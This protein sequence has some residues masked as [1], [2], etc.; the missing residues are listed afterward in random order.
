MADNRQPRAVRCGAGAATGEVA[1]DRR[2]LHVR[3]LLSLGVVGA[4]EPV[5][6]KEELVGL[7]LVD[8]PWDVELGAVVEV[9]AARDRRVVL[10]RTELRRERV[11]VEAI[12]ADAEV[13][14]ID[15]VAVLRV[16]EDLAAIALARVVP[17]VRADLVA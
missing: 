8:R 13:R 16:D 6:A 7:A 5:R 10:H 15:P 4:V 14:A 3:G 2:P 11:V 1:A 12:G 17:T 9:D